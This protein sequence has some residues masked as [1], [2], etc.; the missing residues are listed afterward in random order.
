[1]LVFHVAQFS[2]YTNTSRSYKNKTDQVTKNYHK[3]EK[4]FPDILKRPHT[5]HAYAL[6]IQLAL[7]GSLPYL[8][9]II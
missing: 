6:L 8:G 9:M 3:I 2:P 4:S 7:Q 1:M 5:F